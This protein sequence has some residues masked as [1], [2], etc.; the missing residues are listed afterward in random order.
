MKGQARM[1]IL[2]HCK[3]RP[4]GEHS[5]KGLMLS[6]RIGEPCWSADQHYSAVA[7]KWIDDTHSIL[8]HTDT[9]LNIVGRIDVLDNYIIMFNIRMFYFSFIGNIGNITALRYH[10]ER[11]GLLRSGSR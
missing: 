3:V 2:H 6:A 5:H 10:S 1:L 9:T 7:T 8:T 4:S 11:T